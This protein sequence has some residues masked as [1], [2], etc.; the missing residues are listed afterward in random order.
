[1]VTLGCVLSTVL[2]ADAE[3]YRARAE[4]LVS[5]M[6]LEEKA[7]LSSG[8]TAWTTKAVERLGIPAILLT[9]G[10]H[11][12]RLAKPGSGMSG[13]NNSVPATCFPT[14]PA[15]AATWNVDLIREVGAALGQ[16]S[17]THG[18]QILLGP[19]ANLKRSP[20]AG[21]N[22]E[23]FSE[24]PLLSGRIAAAWIRGV[25]SQGVGASLKHFAAN[26]QESERMV[27]DS[28]VADRALHEIYLRSFEI[29]VREGT[30][31]T[32]MCAYNKVN[33]V[34]AA[35]NK[36]LLTDFL[37][38]DWGFTGI[39]LSDW[40]AVNDRVTGIR[41]GLNLEMPS[42]GGFNDRKI[43]AA[44]QSGELDVA[45]LNASVTPLLAVI[46]RAQAG[47]KSGATFDQDA[48]HAL[49]RK[50]AGEGIVLLKNSEDTLPLAPDR[51]RRI[52]IIGEFAKLP[53]YQGAGS[54]QVNPTRLDN[55]YDELLRSLGD[56]TKV[57]F[58]KGYDWEGESS[59]AMR[60]E[61]VAAARQADHAIV[62]VGLPDSYESEGFDRAALGLPAGHNALVS[63]VAAVAPRTTV[64]LM[65]GSPV[66]LPWVGDADAIVEAYLGGQ[67]GGGAV[68][69]V[70]T[71]RVNPSGKLAETFPVRI[72][73][74]PT[75]PN[76]PGRDQKVLY[77]EGVFVGYRHYDAKKI[78]PLFP[79]GFGLSYTQF[80]FTGLKMND[81]KVDAA[82]GVNVEVTV[83]NIG[84]RAGAEVVQVYLRDNAPAAPSPERE[85]KAFAK[86]LLE[87]GETRTVT[88]QLDRAAFAHYDA[89][90]QAWAVR[91][92]N[93]TVM[94]GSSSRDL[95]LSE[96][97]E[98]EGGPQPPP[99]ITRDSNFAE[100]E[101]HPRGKPVYDA[102]IARMLG[103]QPKLEDLKLSPAD[104]AAA[105]KARET[106]LVF[107]REIPMGKMVMLSQGA[108]TEEALQ[109]ILT[110]INGPSG[111]PKDK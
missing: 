82:A 107:V 39:V 96:K 26:N 75:Y 88:L 29:A 9:D 111:E 15:L 102:F 64:V 35:E 58:A 27:S 53:R 46:L 67:A 43:V 40:G 63:A 38:G 110:A 19:G 45:T 7:G 24:D 94:A 4:E 95:P 60:E 98:V 103:N 34:H 89:R 47:A 92:G 76:F 50:V 83:K 18:V 109:G 54:S 6:T 74:T 30:P 14:A 20:L 56:K 62:F 16:E 101:Q 104:Y 97:V 49:A 87:P 65:N 21:R 8:G 84:R 41:A 93:Y 72:E 28:V 70:L 71:G 17:Q 13:L 22:F 23:Y 3:N 68:A 90:R 61:A 59:Q 57:T 80:R 100:V 51:D 1:L 37:R 32:I 73:D 5:T 42:S 108:F 12:V 52:A 33:G 77:G 25:Q 105:K 106:M 86:V 36:T 10:P 66:S 44:V 78:E 2:R 11:G 85:L 31:W 91:S 79:F 48:H 69:D 81:S 55:A 99:H